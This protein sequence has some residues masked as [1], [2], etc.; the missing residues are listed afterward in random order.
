MKFASIIVSFLFFSMKINSAPNREI[1]RIQDISKSHDELTILTEVPSGKLKNY[2]IFQKRNGIETFN[3]KISTL[4]YSKIKNLLSKFVKD[5]QKKSREQ[6][7]CEIR[8]ESKIIYKGEF[9]FVGCVDPKKDSFN[10]F[11]FDLN[12]ILHNTRN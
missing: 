10:V 4:Q 6:K 9:Q 11:K 1:F 7:G 12:S 2:F 5:E 3:E 8:F